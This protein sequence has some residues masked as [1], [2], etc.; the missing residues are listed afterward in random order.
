MIAIK[1]IFVILSL[2][3]IPVILIP[4]FAQPIPAMPAPSCEGLDCDPSIRITYLL[5]DSGQYS[6]GDDILLTVEVINESPLDS[7]V[8]NLV[9]QANWIVGTP[10]SKSVTI[11]SN[12][13]KTVTV[14]FSTSLTTYGRQLLQ[15]TALGTHPDD[16]SI[17]VE[18]SSLLQV[19]FKPAPTPFSFLALL[20][21]SLVVLGLL[22][23]VISSTRTLDKL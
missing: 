15:V 16:P 13:S 4:S 9:V 22:A 11:P 17:N 21:F 1:F 6:G 3:I 19:P 14:S 7:I 23:F 18:S 20:I 2:L 12:N 8:V 10:I 5:L